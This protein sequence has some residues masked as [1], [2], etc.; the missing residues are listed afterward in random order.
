MDIMV[1]EVQKWIN[2]KYP[3]LSVI[4]DGLTGSST[5]TALIKALQIE[6]GVTADGDFGYST[7]TNCPT[8]RETDTPS[9]ASPSN[10]IYILQGSCW[11]KGYN[12]GGFTGV[13]GEGTT[14]AVKSFQSDAGIDEDGVVTPYILQGLMNT[15]GYAFSD[16]GDL[17]LRYKHEVQLGL[18]KFY[19]SKIGLIAPN[20][21]WERKSHTNLIKACQTEWNSSVDGM[22]GTGTMN[23]APTISQYTS[24]YTNSKRLLQWALA[25]NGF[26][27]GNFLG[28][29]D[30]STYLAVFGFQELMELDADG[31][32]GKNTWA[33]LLS[34]C[35]NTSRTVTAFDTS[36][37]LTAVTAGNLVNLGFTD[38]GRYLTN[39]EGSSFDKKLTAD[40]LQIIENAGLKV[41]PIFQ[42]YGGE[43]S[44]FTRYQGQKDAASAKEAAQNFGF[45]SNTTIYFAVDYDALMT[46]ITSNIIPYFRGINE[47]IGASYRV[48]V[49]GPRAV[50]N[51]LSTYGL[52]IRSFVGDMS[53]GFTGNIGVMMPAN[54]AYDQILETTLSGIGVDKCSASSRKTAI[55]PSEFITYN[56]QNE[57]EVAAAFLPFKQIY[58]LAWQYLQDIQTPSVGVYPSIFNANV[59]ALQYLRS[60][61]Y[62]VPE[63][64]EG[65]S[66][67]GIA[68]QTIAGARDTGFIEL[69]ENTY[70]S[71]VP[72]TLSI[73]DPGDNTVI[74]FAH[75]A[76]TLNTCVTGTF[77][78]DFEFLERDV[79]AFSGWAGDLMQMAGVLQTAKNQGYDYFTVKDMSYMIGAEPGALQDYHLFYKSNDSYIEM[80]TKD[81]G[82]GR[83]DLYQD[84]DAY[85]I[86]RLYD[87]SKTKLHIA[88]NDYYMVSKQYENRFSIFKRELL[89]Q[90]NKSTL[91]DVALEFSTEQVAFLSAMFEKIFGEFSSNLYGDTLAQAF[92]NKINSL[93]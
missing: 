14:A 40:E 39:V 26:Y 56:T 67:S 21:L 93:I 76:A 51:S 13:F 32:A 65:I 6:I 57:P 10:L 29:F 11:C 34:S 81:A 15:D 18:N 35:G 12:P 82:F 8:L 37:R 43:A 49:Y 64:S 53:S 69:A 54:W 84:V 4:E 22:W 47:E 92:D 74:E 62:D 5:F 55:S 28:N 2:T 91:Y 17:N 7:L 42:T 24:G 89:S 46:D 66:W 30:T 50:C 72:E 79:D 58:E 86:S 20:G 45:P 73:T 44:Y 16:T 25:V 88:L 60:S 31:I 83:V 68:W 27:S 70:S 71:I 77:G 38:V 90:F 41:F 80:D 61:A 19:G 85:N 48:G 23:M 75:Y 3:Q 78:F 36:T 59:M 1:L 87:L 33:S 52:A 63:D 9:S